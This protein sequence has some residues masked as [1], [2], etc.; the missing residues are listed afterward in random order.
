M[1]WFVGDLPQVGEVYSA[2]GQIGRVAVTR[3][4]ADELSG[5]SPQGSFQH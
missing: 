2:C 1:G 5:G 4:A 3:E